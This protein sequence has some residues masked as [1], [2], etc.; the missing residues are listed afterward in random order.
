MCLIH[1]IV[2]SHSKHPRHELLSFCTDLAFGGSI[3]SSCVL[4]HSDKYPGAP[5]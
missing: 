3:H 4:V 5:S 1:A 2:T